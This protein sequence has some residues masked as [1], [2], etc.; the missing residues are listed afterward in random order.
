MN[1]AVIR[2][3][4]KIREKNSRTAWV[5]YAFGRRCLVGCVP[6]YIILLH[7]NLYII[8]MYLCVT[9]TRS[10]DGGKKTSRKRRFT[11]NSYSINW[12]EYQFFIAKI[13]FTVTDGR[14]D[15]SRRIAKSGYTQIVDA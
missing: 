10:G 1:V 15:L 8:I 14:L 9:A 4:K 11:Y 12:R 5:Y 13:T 7:K 2:E 6:T 3:L